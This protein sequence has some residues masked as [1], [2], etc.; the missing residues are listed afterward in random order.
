MK[1]SG[2][3]LKILA[4]AHRSWLEWKEHRLQGSKVAGTASAVPSQES[5]SE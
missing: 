2:A 1:Q 5:Q 4:L 3:R